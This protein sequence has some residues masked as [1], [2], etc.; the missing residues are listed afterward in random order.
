MFFRR[1]AAGFDCCHANRGVRGLSSDVGLDD[2]IVCLNIAIN[3][4]NSLKISSRVVSFKTS[5]TYFSRHLF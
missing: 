1:R 2:S 3:R 4:E 5:V